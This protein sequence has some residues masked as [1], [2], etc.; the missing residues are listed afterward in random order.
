MS[1]GLTTTVFMNDN[2]L[3]NLELKFFEDGIVRGY[4]HLEAVE[5]INGLKGTEDQSNTENQLRL[6]ALAHHTTV[7]VQSYVRN[8]RNLSPD[9]RPANPIWF[10]EGMGQRYEIH[11]RRQSFGRFD[12]GTNETLLFAH[13]PVVPQIFYGELTPQLCSA[14]SQILKLIPNGVSQLLEQQQVKIHVRSKDEVHRLLQT[15]FPGSKNNGFFTIDER[16]QIDSVVPN[17]LF[18]DLVVAS[19]LHELGHA[20][21]FALDQ[22]SAEKGYLAHDRFNN[23]VKHHFDN[24]GKNTYPQQVPFSKYGETNWMEW[25]AVAWMVY[26]FSKGEW[27]CDTILSL[28]PGAKNFYQR[29]Q[30]QDPVGYLLMVKLEQYFEQGQNSERAFSYLTCLE[31]QKFVSQNPKIDAITTQK[32]R[33]YDIDYTMADEFYHILTAD[34][35]ETERLLQL[36]GYAALHPDYEPVFSII[37]TSEMRTLASEGPQ[38]PILAQSADKIV[39]N[40]RDYRT[41]NLWDV[42]SATL[43][44][45]FKRHKTFGYDF[46]FH[47]EFLTH[48]DVQD[49]L[50]SL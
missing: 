22:I 30:E 26:F 37:T 38:C 10:L 9:L 25:F 5:N 35:P 43:E 40:F 33:D 19:L 6:E 2:D 3:S 44:E 7:D 17:D 34:I 39:K 46:N 32:W 24:R 1:A 16:G 21:G 15:E 13:H 12:F 29:W 8:L 36:Y 27:G 42:E 47:P 11:G 14:I 31:A 4:E 28:I 50:Q 41:T 18:I 23:V 45:Q 49:Y 48:P 20:V